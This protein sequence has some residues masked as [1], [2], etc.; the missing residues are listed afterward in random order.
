[1][2]IMLILVQLVPLHNY[3]RLVGNNNINLL[4][5]NTIT[6]AKMKL[7]PFRVTT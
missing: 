7:I 2:L 5:S 3:E 1:M 6:T 4:K